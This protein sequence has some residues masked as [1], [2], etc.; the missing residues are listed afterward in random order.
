[1]GVT[2]NYAYT[3]SSVEVTSNASGKTFKLPMI[4]LSKHVFNPTLFYDKNGFST[5]VGVR[6][7]TGFVASHF[8]FD[9][10][11]TG[12]APETVV[13]AQISYRFPET[14]GLRGLS[15]YLQGNNLTDAPTRSYYGTE[16]QTDTLQ[17]FGR[18]VYA[19]A[20]MRF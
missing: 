9:E 15:L 18:V 1:M 7:R 10:Q 4:G 20:T 6:Y 17:R 3:E 19:G 12:N 16:A 8:G 2:M 14:S 11:I 5:R 13:D